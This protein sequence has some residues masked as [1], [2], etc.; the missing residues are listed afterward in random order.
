M[1]WILVVVTV[2]LLLPS[3][4]A[5]TTKPSP[6]FASITACNGHL[7]YRLYDNAVLYRTNTTKT[8]ITATANLSLAMNSSLPYCF[9]SGELEGSVTF[10]LDGWYTFDCIFRNTSTGWVWVDGHVVCGD[11]H[12]YQPSLWD[13]PLMIQTTTMAKTK[14]LP[15]RAHIMVNTSTHCKNAQNDSNSAGPP[16]L[17][18]YWKREPLTSDGH[19]NSP[20]LQRL[21][22]QDHDEMRA[23]STST[24]RKSDQ[25]DPTA[26][27]YNVF[28]SSS[29]HA[30]FH[31]FLSKP[32]QHREDLQRNLRNGW[33]YWLRSSILSIVKLPEGLVLSFRICKL[34]PQSA[35]ATL[36]QMSPPLSELQQQQQHCLT[37]AVPDLTDIVRVDLLA[38]DRSYGAYNIS[39]AGRTFQMEC[40]VTGTRQQEMQY[41]I[42]VSS[43]HQQSSSPPPHE[44]FDLVL[45]IVP[46]YAWY[47]PGT[48]SAITNGISFHTP[49]L[50]DLN[51]TVI[52][53]D[54]SRDFGFEKQHY[55]RHSP[56]GT[57][58]KARI[59]I[60][61]RLTGHDQKFGFVAGFEDDS[62]APK[63]VPEIEQNVHIKRRDEEKRI[64]S[65]FGNNKT[66]VAIAIQSAVMWTL[67]YNPIENGP[68]MP[69]SRSSNW[70]FAESVK[71][72]NSD[73]AYVIF[74]ES[75]F[76]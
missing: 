28:D 70:D 26:S 60:R 47:R 10:L 32:E 45:D 62:R 69:V 25:H 54:L 41:L 7:T 57:N 16:T 5:T 64:R 55:Q 65:K 53:E 67:V 37:R 61:L 21:V 75:L 27:R 14:T 13:N 59:P 66:E 9:L 36:L 29:I 46:R 38:Y 68:F 74:G 72:A 44:D 58:D 17:Q 40:S 8:G 11:N 1:T 73:W 39:F 43:C 15:F 52:E 31:P 19:E 48:Y 63:S 23:S 12:A 76:V 49:G 56:T 35:N 71:A 2:L 51:F 22:V 34:T 42:S 20:L 24:S 33:G 6:S 4:M 18:V 30:T 3:L 50:G